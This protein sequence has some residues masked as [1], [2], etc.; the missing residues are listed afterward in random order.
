M[1]WERFTSLTPEMKNFLAAAARVLKMLPGFSPDLTN[2]DFTI[3][4][5]TNSSLG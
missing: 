4:P 1:R 3:R 2:F 5:I